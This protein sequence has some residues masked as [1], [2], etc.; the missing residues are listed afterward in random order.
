MKSSGSK[1]LQLYIPLNTPPSYERTQP[2]AKAIAELADG[3]VVGS[4]LVE[5]MG[6]MAEQSPEKIAAALSDVL[7]GIRQAIDTLA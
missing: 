6:A 5:K 4:V 2:F 3:V 1:G 7:G